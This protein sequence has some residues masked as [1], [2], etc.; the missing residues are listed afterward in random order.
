MKKISLLVV[1][2]LIVAAGPS[3][4]ARV[5]TPFVI[6]DI[7]VYGSDDVSPEQIRETQG[8]L[9]GKF[10]RKKALRSKKSRRLAK[11]LREELVSAVREQGGF[12]WVRLKLVTLGLDDAGRRPVMILF[13]VIEKRDMATRFPFRSEPVGEVDDVSG[14]IEL[15]R[16]YAKRGRDAERAGEDV[17]RLDCQAFYCIEGISDSEAERLD[18]EFSDRVPKY[19]DLLVRIMQEDKDPERR[20]IALYLLTYLRV[21][22]EVSRV[23]SRALL[24][25]SPR[26]RDAAFDVFNDIAVEHREVPVPIHEIARAMDFPYP[27][28]RLHAL[29]VMLS[30]ADHDDYRDFLLHSASKRIV[31]HLRLKN[32]STQEMAHTVLT[33]LSGESYGS[34]DYDAWEKWLWKMSRRRGNKD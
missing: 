28:D 20:A 30:L 15:W 27:E 5:R 22:A 19:R 13:D 7:Q 10:L 1:A 17:E 6:K 23:V 33:L 34:R 31:K 25:P 12:G 11:E 32:P 2:A 26:V 29:A 24:D 8:D 16:G 18:D 9:I 14:L 4:G 3:M 21:G